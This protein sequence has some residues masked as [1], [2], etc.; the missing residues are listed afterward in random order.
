MTS[1]CKISFKY[2]GATLSKDGTITAEV[3]IRID[4]ARPQRTEQV[5]DKK[6]HQLRH[7]VLAL[8][9]P[10][11]L[12]PILRLRQLDHSREHRTQIIGI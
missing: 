1:L 5:V 10:R 6:F 3:R 11:S 2:M 4:I 7:Q 12:H 8:Q 9:V